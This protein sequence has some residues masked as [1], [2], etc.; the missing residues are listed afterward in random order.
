[1]QRTTFESPSRS[2]AGLNPGELID[3]SRVRAKYKCTTSTRRNGVLVPPF[4]GD[5]ITLPAALDPSRVVRYPFRSEDDPKRF[6]YRQAMLVR[7]NGIESAWAP[8]KGAHAAAGGPNGTRIRHLD[9]HEGLI[10]LACLPA[11]RRR[12]VGPGSTCAAARPPCRT[13]RRLAA[14]R[15]RPAARR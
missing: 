1:M 3:Y 12:P 15:S 5:K 14:Q 7:L 11:H 10:S 6:G 9:Q 13:A 4:P 2:S 8:L